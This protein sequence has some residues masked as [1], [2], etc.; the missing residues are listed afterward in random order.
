LYYEGKVIKLRTNIL[1]N[2]PLPIEIGNV[3]VLQIH[4]TEK[5]L[6]MQVP[7]HKLFREIVYC[8]GITH[9]WHRR[10]RERERENN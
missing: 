7:K 6:Y 5:F 1:E 8:R 9:P 4:S 10:E 2:A 3:E